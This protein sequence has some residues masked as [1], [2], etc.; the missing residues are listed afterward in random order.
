MKLKPATATTYPAELLTNTVGDWDEF[1]VSDNDPELTRALHLPAHIPRGARFHRGPCVHVFFDGSARRGF[2]TAGYV[3]L[4]TDGSEIL[5]VGEKLS[6]GMT[7]NEAEAEAL[8]KAL[9]KVDEL[10]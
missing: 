7:N 6:E 8:A 10:R 9:M 1:E 4:G 3:L 5:R 2:G